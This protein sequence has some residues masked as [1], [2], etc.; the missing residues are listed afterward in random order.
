[1]LVREVIRYWIK[2]SVERHA[3]RVTQRAL[4]RAR[5]NPGL[6]AGG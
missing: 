2:S 4:R 3:A 1:M 5:R 6:D